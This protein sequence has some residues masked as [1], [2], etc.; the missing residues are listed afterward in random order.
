MFKI[1]K[2]YRLRKDIIQKIEQL[3]AE[4]KCSHGDAIELMVNKY[5]ENKD[6]K[7]QALMEDMS[8]LL[9]EKLN[10]MK[11][12]L[13][14]IR[15]TS[16]VIDRDTKMMLEFWNHYFVVN[17]FKELGTTDK[18]KTEEF[19]EAE[20]LIKKRIAHHH[21]KKLDREMKRKKVTN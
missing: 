6:K 15:I 10:E 11:E 17:D 14:R 3:A 7:H 20:A 9:D 12:D 1:K 8:N 2:T 19:K 21:Q 13:K 18:F 16:N 4:E 5:F